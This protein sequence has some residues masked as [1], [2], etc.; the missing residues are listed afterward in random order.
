MKLPHAASLAATFVALSLS[1]QALDPPPSAA[2]ETPQTRPNIVVIM[3]DD[4]DVDSLPVMRHLLS[5]PEGSW[6]QFSNA[7]VNLSVCGPSRATLLTGQYPH[8]NGVT[9][10]D[11][12]RLN[13]TN[14]LPVWLDN[15]GYHTGLVGKYLNNVSVSPRH[16][17]PGMDYYNGIEKKRRDVDAYSSAAVDFIN[18]STDPFFLYLSYKGPHKAAHPPARYRD[19]DAYLPEF[20]PNV[21]ELDLSDKPAYW[22]KMKLLS[23][24]QLRMWEAERLNSQRELMGIDDGI[25]QVINA[26]KAKGILDNTLI[27]FTA[28]NGFTWGSHR[29]VNKLCPYEEC[30]N[31]PLFIRFPGQQGNR[32]DTN[33]VSNVDLAATI[34]DYAGVNPGIPQDGQSLIPLLEDPGTEW[35]N[36][37]L[38]QR[39]LNS[40]YGI[41]TQDWKYIEYTTGERELY[42]L[43]ADP[44]EMQSVHGQAPYQAI[45]S[46]L[47]SK[48][49][50]LRAR[51]SIYGMA[52]TANGE[53][54]VGV[55]ITAGANHRAVTDEWGLYVLNNVPAGTYTLTAAKS[56]YVFSTRAPISLPPSVVGQ[57]F[58]GTRVGYSLSGRITLD[59]QPLA[60][61]TVSDGNGHTAVTN[62][63]GNYDMVNLPPGAYTVTPSLAGY[64]FSPASRSVTITNADVV[65][66]NFSATLL[67]YTISGTITLDGQPLAG[68]TVSDG[69]GHTA[70]TNDAG[71]YDMVNLPPGAYTVTPS[72]AGYAFS[73][74]SRSVTITN[75]DVVNANFSAT[76][77]TYT[78]SG[79]ITLDG[80]P[81]AGVTVSD[82]NGHTAVTN[83]AGYYELVNLLPG[84]YTLTPTLEGYSFDP[85]STTVT[86]VNAGVIQ[87]FS[88]I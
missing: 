11:G 60:G 7:F 27:I 10:N 65:N 82:G 76:L 44:Y 5:H 50:G 8:H 33:V 2:A 51:S 1:L 62:D 53:P 57:D 61:V 49:A 18:S 22:R 64:A 68:V 69:N 72:L 6:V 29:K 56:G 4:Q 79:T 59:G 30:S 58:T 39:H 63:A 41:R 48:L 84:D 75:A 20:R 54:I 80:Q 78:I 38:L 17:I 24:A 37:V 25:L 40:Y 26:L 81:L 23:P 47:A 71:N 42:D 77:L 3:T 70:V 67:T 12:K 15:A 55:T 66:A 34:A 88:A 19:V 83:D 73:P 13:T 74:A 16:P 45:Q 46:N 86:I 31:V 14:I 36:E 32:V 87:D 85:A 9:G 35:P 43:N 21:N 28:D 52:R